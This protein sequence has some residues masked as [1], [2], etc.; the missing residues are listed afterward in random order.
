VTKLAVLAVA[1]GLVY[2]GV[3]VSNADISHY[4]SGIL[5]AEL[6]AFGCP[7]SSFDAGVGLC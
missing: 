2:A 4:T 5:I 7:G 3:D 1:P 6:I